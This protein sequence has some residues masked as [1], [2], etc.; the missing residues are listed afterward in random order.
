ML[1]CLTYG[2]CARASKMGLV[3]A[4]LLGSPVTA[5]PVEILA[6]GDSLTAGYGLPEPAGFVP[7][8]QKWL[9]QRGHDVKLINAGVSG[10]TTAGGLSRVAWSLTPQTDAIVVALG[11]NDMLRGLPPEVVRTNINGILEIADQS[12]LQI[13]IVG[14]MA[15]GNYGLDYKMEFDSIYP[16]AAKAYDAVYQASFFEG[17]LGNSEDPASIRDYLQPDGIHPNAEGVAKIVDG[18]GP[19]IEQLILRTQSRD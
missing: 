14:M 12:D 16:D 13:M 4:L 18:M 8:M 19:R 9:T 7:Q 1:Q 10:D 5:E 6:L 2:A 15:P 17:L 11:G 3:A